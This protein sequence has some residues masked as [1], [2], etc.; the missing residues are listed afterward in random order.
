VYDERIF[1]LISATVLLAAQIRFSAQYMVGTTTVP[2][3]NRLAAKSIGIVSEPA[4]TE[5]SKRRDNT[6]SF[7]H[8]I[9]S[10]SSFHHKYQEA[11]QL[12]KN[13]A[14]KKHAQN[15]TVSTL[16]CTIGSLQKAVA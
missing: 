5:K 7:H 13:N 8:S 2:H 11:T 15:P 3:L 1:W 16:K 10:L 12:L 9:C 6:P 14:Y 4:A